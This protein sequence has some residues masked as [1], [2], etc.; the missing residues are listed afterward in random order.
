M[1]DCTCV[2]SQKYPMLLI[3]KKN[4]AISYLYYPDCNAM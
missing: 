1:Y 4:K 2:F 3:F